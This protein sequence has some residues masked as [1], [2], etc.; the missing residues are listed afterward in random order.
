LSKNGTVASPES[1]SPEPGRQ[2]GEG[3]R[4]RDHLANERTLL[5]WTRT[6]LA[7]IGLGF[8]VARFG[9]LL[10]EVAGQGSPAQSRLAAVIGICLIVAGLVSSAASVVRFF[11]AR[12]QIE[13]GRFEAGY[14]PTLL[15]IAM[16]GVLGVTLAVYLTVNS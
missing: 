15:L 1:A 11:R 2:G 5:A 12:R 16:I 7:L 13:E 10:R 4:T 6:S 3:D 14:W 8:V 9:F